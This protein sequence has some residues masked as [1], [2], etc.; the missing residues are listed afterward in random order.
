[1]HT[2]AIPHIR[3]GDR[4]LKMPRW[5]GVSLHRTI[6]IHRYSKTTYIPA[7]LSAG[8]KNVRQTELGGAGR[9]GW[10]EKSPKNFFEKN[11]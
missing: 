10:R 11:A 6:L 9:L 2:R 1:M 4:V 3:K 5:G 8:H 7:N